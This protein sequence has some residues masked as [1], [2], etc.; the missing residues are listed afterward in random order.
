MGKRDA[1]R[2]GKHGQRSEW[3]RPIKLDRDDVTNTCPPEYFDRKPFAQSSGPPN[4]CG[5]NE[6][7]AGQGRPSGASFSALPQKA[8]RFRQGAV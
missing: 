1:K 6:G 3:I 4:T 7:C 5:A 2:F 8:G